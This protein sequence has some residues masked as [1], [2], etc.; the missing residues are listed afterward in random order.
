MA[1]KVQDI[2]H[3]NTIITT[4]SFVYTFSTLYADPVN[5]LYF[6]TTSNSS[7]FMFNPATGSAQ[8][9]A[10]VPVI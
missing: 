7:F 2:I 3:N 1:I 8:E 9:I 5:N 10:N 6:F 4:V